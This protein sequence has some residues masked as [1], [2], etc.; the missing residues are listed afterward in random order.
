MA[1][2]GEY[3]ADG[4]PQDRGTA[5]IPG[6]LG[7]KWGWSDVGAPE[8]SFGPGFTV[9]AHTYGT[10]AEQT[11][12]VLAA[13]PQILAGLTGMPPEAVRQLGIATGGAA[14]QPASTP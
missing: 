6:V 5:R 8:V 1:T 9:A 13:L 12:D 10:S 3:A 14:G 2:A 4:T 11:A 7:T